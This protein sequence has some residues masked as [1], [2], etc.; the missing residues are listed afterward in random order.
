METQ[1]VSSQKTGLVSILL[2]AVTAVLLYDWLFRGQL[3]GLNVLLVVAAFYCSVLLL[4]PGRISLKNEY[5]W[6]LLLLIAGF[7]TTFFIYNNTFLLVLNALALVLLIPAQAGAMT[8]NNSRS[9]YS[10]RAASDICYFLFIRP[11]HKIGDAFSTLF[12]KKDGSDQKKAVISVVIGLAVAIPVLALLLALLASA[13]MVF[14]QMLL[15]LFSLQTVLDILGYLLAIGVFFCLFGSTLQSLLQKKRAAISESKTEPARFNLLSVYIIL[16]SVTVLMLIFAGVQCLF[17]FGSASLP[18]GISYSAYA[19]SGFFQLCAAAVLVFL[20]TA[21]CMAFTRHAKNRQKT[22]LNILYTLLN[23]STILLLISSFARMVLYEQE[24][25]FTPL[26]LYVQAFIILLG[27]LVAYTL[28]RI[29][30]QK[31]HIAKFV[32]LTIATCLL[33]LSFFNVDAFIARHNGRQLKLSIDM[34]YTT[35]V[36]TPHDVDYLL[37]LSVDALPYYIDA[38]GD[39]RDFI[40][41]DVGVQY[42]RINASDSNDYTFK[43]ESEIPLKNY[44]IWQ[45]AAIITRMYDDCKRDSQ[46]IRSYNIGRQTALHLLSE[47]PELLK[48]CRDYYYKYLEEYEFSFFMD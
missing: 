12:I 20:L 13:D 29:W 18:E 3:L 44:I 38:L 23:L 31:F 22:F 41:T 24:F 37:T 45:R 48:A 28:V 14:N 5:N 17:L 21:I 2:A 15:H 42:D 10:F 19:R 34:D 1:Q 46:D 32:F 25:M 39:G 9:V 4:H 6:F 47:R 40:Q 8:G 33:A 16:I 43:T 36:Q 26:R 35:H 7:C 30:H 27:L 11:Y